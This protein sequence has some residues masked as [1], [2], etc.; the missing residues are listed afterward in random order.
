MAKKPKSAKGSIKRDVLAKAI[1][2]YLEWMIENGYAWGT[3]SIYQGVLKHFQSF[4]ARRKIMWDDIVTYNTLKAFEKNNRFYHAATAIRGL[5]RYLFKHKLIPAPIKTPLAPLPD[6]YEDYLQYYVETRAVGHNCLLR[7]RDVLAALNDYLIKHKIDLSAV[8]IEQLDDFLAGFNARFKPATCRHNRTYL[9]G[10]IKY[11]Y[12]ERKIISRDLASLIVGA[13]MFAQAQPPKFLRPNEVKELF[14]ALGKGT[15][16]ELRTS[17]MVHL[18][19]TL[20]LRPKEIGLIRL[21]D[22]AFSRSEINVADRKSQN[23]IELPLPEITLKAI[24]AYVVG[25]RPASD[26]RALFLGFHAPYASVSAATVSHDIT[27][28]MRKINP[29]ASAYWLRHTYAQNLLESGASIFD[30]KQMLGHGNVQSS[31]RYVHINIKLMRE[32]LFDDPL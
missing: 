21:D 15:G 7:T 17:T 18:G 28:A 14:C 25:A 2:D 24:A 10:F 9:R 12:Y 13:P 32:V 1:D 27:A 20:G 29:L 8:K 16:K 11:L 19:Y 22:I 6:I 4:V 23:P 26:Q 31:R 5:S 30:V 3:I